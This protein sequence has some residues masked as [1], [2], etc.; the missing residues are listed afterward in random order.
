MTTVYEMS[1]EA[2]AVKASDW[3]LSIK[4]KALVY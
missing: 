1:A 3:L 4:S 2:K